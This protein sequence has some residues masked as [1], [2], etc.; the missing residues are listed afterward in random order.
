[1]KFSLFLVSFCLVLG[2][3]LGSATP[4]STCTK[5]NFSKNVADT[6]CDD[7]KNPATTTSTVSP[8]PSTTTDAKNLVI[9]VTDASTNPAPVNRRSDSTAPYTATTGSAIN[10]VA[11][12][13]EEGNLY[14]Y[15]SLSYVSQKIVIYYYFISFIQ[16]NNAVQLF[17]LSLK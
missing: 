4:D 13:T 9:I 8:I 16:L 6:C 2:N 3:F 7:T 14:N 17:V 5:F 1:M 11:N 12:T 15:L 10:T